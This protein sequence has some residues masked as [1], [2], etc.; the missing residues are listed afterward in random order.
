MCWS[1]Q[2]PEDAEELIDLRIPAEK[3]LFVGQL[4][5]DAADRPGIHSRVVLLHPQQDLWGSVPKCDNFV[6]VLSERI[7]IYSCQ[8]EISEFDIESFPLNK[9]VLRF[10]VTMHHSIG[11]TVL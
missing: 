6:G 10:E 11:V 3:T 4:E 7:A 1:T 5:E 9:D 2:D 8:P